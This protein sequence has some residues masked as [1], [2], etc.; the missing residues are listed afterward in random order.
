ME[1]AAGRAERNIMGEE[2]EVFYE[3]P[4]VFPIS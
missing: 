3:E 1:E 4:N 2:K